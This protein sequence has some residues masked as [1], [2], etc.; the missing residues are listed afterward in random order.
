[1][2][3]TDHYNLNL[4]EGTDIVNPLVQ[5]NP[6]YTAIDNAMYAN[7]LRVIGT[8]TELTTGTVHA[9]TRADQDIAAFKFVATSDYN[10]G[11]T[12][13]VDGVS[14][15]ARVTDGS[16]IPTGAYKIN[17]TVLC[18]LDGSVLN[19][20]N[21]S[22]NIKAANVSYTNTSSGLSATNV[23]DAIDEVA[24]KHWTE[25]ASVTVTGGTGSSN[26]TP[27]SIPATAKE[28]LLQ[29]KIGN[30]VTASTVSLRGQS[31]SNCSCT[32]VNSSG[33]ITTFYGAA[34]NLST[35]TLLSSVVFRSGAD[36]AVTATAY[37]R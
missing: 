32:N 21:V 23:Q 14:V 31:S 35:G 24:S 3:Y 12:F 2:Q 13:T 18:I 15:T 28:V 1:M 7:K 17:S 4:P 10:A 36:I 16:S 8:A 37:Y 34:I 19:L 29:T 6:N 9:L 5:D 25:A 11:D 26:S 20:I 22:G 30:D 33:A 27:V